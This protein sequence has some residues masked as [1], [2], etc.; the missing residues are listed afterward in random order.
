MGES[1]HSKNETKVR[2]SVQG[3]NG[4][5]QSLHLNLSGD[6]R[7]RCESN[8]PP[9]EITHIFTN[10]RECVFDKISKKKFFKQLI[11]HLLVKI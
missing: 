2:E 8:K 1:R 7:I 11:L 3:C 10:L 6:S 9:Q 5:T 4:K